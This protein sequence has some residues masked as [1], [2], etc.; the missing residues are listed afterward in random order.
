MYDHLLFNS[1]TNEYWA[2]NSNLSSPTIVYQSLVNNFSIDCRFYKT[3]YISA[4]VSSQYVTDLPCSQVDPSGQLET[5]RRL[6]I[7]LRYLYRFHINAK[8][9]SNGKLEVFTGIRIGTSLW[10]DE[11]PPG[12][13][14]SYYYI[15]SY[16]TSHSLSLTSIQCLFIVRIYPFSTYNGHGFINN[17][18]IDLEAA[19]GSPYFLNGGLAYRFNR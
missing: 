9:D 4:A 10:T 1:I 8:Q 12:M 18:G 11:L 13:S 3:S 5:I 19:I 7:G 2:Y 17:L 16:H 15:G 6:N 14:D